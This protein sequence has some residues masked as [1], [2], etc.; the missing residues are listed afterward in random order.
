MKISQKYITMWAPGRVAWAP[1]EPWIFSFDDFTVNPHPAKMVHVMV[2]LSLL[3]TLCDLELLLRLR[4]PPTLKSKNEKS[5]CPEQLGN[6]GCGVRGLW[7][8]IEQ[9]APCFWDVW[10][11]CW[12][13]RRQT[14]PGIVLTLT[15][16]WSGG[17][18]HFLNLWSTILS[19]TEVTGL[20]AGEG[21]WENEVNHK[22]HCRE[23]WTQGGG[24][25]TYL[26]WHKQWID[27]IPLISTCW[28]TV[29][30]SELIKVKR[31]RR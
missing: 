30:G 17:R 23:G 9:R 29:R 31:R 7:K 21:R 24:S 1:D 25:R 4:H 18:T 16:L 8:L 11:W 27:E 13:L 28:V 20:R 10:F 19:I 14:I 6:G 22:W 5:L 3:S 15:E 12:V 26:K 2:S